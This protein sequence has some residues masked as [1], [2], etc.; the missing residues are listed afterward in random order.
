VLSTASQERVS[1]GLTIF[2]AWMY[3]ESDA[4]QALAQ[5]Y[6][7]RVALHATIEVILLSLSF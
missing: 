2:E 5:A 4:V 6:S 1:S 3:H 7:E